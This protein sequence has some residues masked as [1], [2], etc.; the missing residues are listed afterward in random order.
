MKR[1]NEEK[2]G[3]LSKFDQLVLRYL[4]LNSRIGIKSP[5]K[6]ILPQPFLLMSSF[7]KNNFGQ[8]NVFQL[9]HHF[10]FSDGGEAT[11]IIYTAR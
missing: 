5:K 11:S 8:F 4:L 3:H 7:S 2:W 6:M 9:I 1:N 10:I